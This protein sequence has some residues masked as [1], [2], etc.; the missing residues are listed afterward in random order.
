MVII[1]NKKILVLFGITVLSFIV[2]SI[3]QPSIFLTLR[4]FQSLSV[5]IPDFGLLA[6]AIYICMLTGG[7]DLSIVATANLSG[8]IAAYIL[9]NYTNPGLSG[10]YNNLIIAIA[11]IV[12]LLV[13]IIC[14]LVNGLLVTKAGITPILATLGTMGLYGGLGIIITKGLGITPLPDKFVAIGNGMFL[15]IPIPLYVFVFVF[16]LL[17]L[18]LN[19]TLF[20]FQTYMIGANPIAARFSGINVNSVLVRVYMTS[21]LLCGIAAI[22]MIAKAGSARSGYGAA[23]LLP[24]ILVAV[25]GGTDPSGGFGSVTGMI[26][27]LVLLQILQSGFNILGFSSFFKN[28]IWGG[29]LLIVMVLNFVGERLTQRMQFRRARLSNNR[30]DSK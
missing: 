20:G 27:A 18:I 13:S 9:F 10:M 6:L 26:L 7:I 5:Q 2:M 17:A 4:N 28:V 8:I 15:K 22:I 12:G 21:G 16:L 30:I 24:A 29:M 1:K 14:G 3:L 25:L 23:F 11:I 19:K